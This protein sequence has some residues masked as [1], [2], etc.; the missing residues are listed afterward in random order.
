LCALKT[1]SNLAGKLARWSFFLEEFNMNIVHK[2]GA[3]LT[4]A[5]GLS[6]CATADG[7]SSD[8]T[9]RLETMAALEE[10][11]IYGSLEELMADV[12]ATLKVDGEIMEVNLLC[13]FIKAYPCSKCDQPIG[14][15][16]AKV[17]GACG[18]ARHVQCMTGKPG[19][20]YWFCGDCSQKFLYGHEDAALNI[21]LHHLLRGA[22][23]YPGAD[24]GM[25]NYMKMSYRFV[26]GCLI[27][28]TERGDRIIPPPCLRED[29][30]QKV[31]DD[32]LHQGWERTAQVL[33]QTY[34]WKDLRDQVRK[35]C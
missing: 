31:H 14:E 2:S 9:I 30:I 12:E 22:S 20:G 26:R 6:R 34:F 27:W 7:S 35:V 1:A 29:I 33:E 11:G 4:N 10:E 13:K 25:R 3:T 5:D 32:L 23:T 18:E 17:C 8:A 28:T 24:R 16:K 21:P 15:A 19:I